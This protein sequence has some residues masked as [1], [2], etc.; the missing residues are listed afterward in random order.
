M[1]LSIDHESWIWYGLLDDSLMDHG[2]SALTCVNLIS[3]V[4]LLI[5][6]HVYHMNRG[7]PLLFYNFHFTENLLERK[8]NFWREQFE[9]LTFLARFFIRDFFILLSSISL[10]D[11]HGGFAHLCYLE[12]VRILNSFSLFSLF[13]FFLDWYW[14]EYGLRSVFRCYFW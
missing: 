2:F 13:F 7:F 4:V 6:L 8:K 5:S 1:C 10:D 3:N 12:K 9:N 14:L 11:F